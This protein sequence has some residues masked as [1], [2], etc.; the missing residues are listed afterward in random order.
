MKILSKISM[1]FFLVLFIAV[2][3]FLV[4][5]GLKLIPSES[6]LN[7]LDY[8]YAARDLRIGIFGVGA[9]LIFISVA[10]YQF[11]IV[12]IHQQKNIA[13]NNPDGQVSISLSAIEEFI[14][15]IGSSLPEV[16]DLKADCIATKKGIDISTK[17]IFW[18]DTNIPEVTEKIQ[19]L[20]KTRVQEMLGIDE[21]IIVKVHVTKIAN[22]EEAKISK[23]G[24]EKEDVSIPFRGMEYRND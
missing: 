4:A 6:I 20:I 10:A 8:I 18:S 13:F 22:R 1:L 12:R 24:K 11:T 19:S 23:K 15:R 2:G 5:V 3:L 9:L 16:K 14:R 21:P 17:I 7:A